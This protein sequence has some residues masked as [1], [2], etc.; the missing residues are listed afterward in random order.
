MTLQMANLWKFICIRI[1]QKRFTSGHASASFSFTFK[2]ACSKRLQVSW[3]KSESHK[4]HESSK[5]SQRNRCRS[6]L[7]VWSAICQN[8]NT[9]DVHGRN[10]APVDM[11]NLPCLL[12][13]A[14][15]HI[16]SQL[17]S[18][19]SCIN[20]PQ[21]WQPP[22]SFS[23]TSVLKKAVLLSLFNTSRQANPETKMEVSEL[24]VNFGGRRWVSCFYGWVM[25]HLHV[26]WRKGNWCNSSDLQR[27][28]IRFH[29]NLS[30]V[31]E[32]SRFPKYERPTA[33]LLKFPA[34]PVAQNWSLN[35]ERTSL[36]L[37]NKFLEDSWRT[38][39]EAL[40]CPSV[41][42]KGLCNQAP[43]RCVSSHLS[44]SLLLPVLAYSQATLEKMCQ[45][46]MA[47]PPVGAARFAGKPCPPRVDQ[48]WLDQA[49]WAS[50]FGCSRRNL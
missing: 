11:E 20:S 5:A 2:T 8:K 49:E 37:S 19:V 1:F 30:V 34:P 28:F 7:R 27:M 35:W 16:I 29:E 15:F 48:G 17:V 41:R 18:R 44:Y 40:I 23:A 25:F 6:D 39:P 45:P 4:V 50:V 43:S 42:F 9:S 13:F 36:I 21:F 3:R 47:T 33:R 24:F 10:P 38:A 12:F 22:D 14:R 32:K 46:P 31:Q 26:A